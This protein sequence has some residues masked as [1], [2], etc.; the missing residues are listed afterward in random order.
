[1]FNGCTRLQGNT[2]Q[3][4]VIVIVIIGWTS[5]R[6]HCQTNTGVKHKT[7]K[8]GKK[9]FTDPDILKPIN[10]VSVTGR[11][12]SCPCCWV[13]PLHHQQLL[14]NSNHLQNSTNCN[15]QKPM[16]SQF[17]NELNDKHDL[18]ILIFSMNMTC[19]LPD[20]TEFFLKKSQK[21]TLHLNIGRKCY[22]G[23]LLNRQKYLYNYRV[24]FT[25]C[26]VFWDGKS[27]K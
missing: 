26:S 9:D 24:S 12:P 27:G 25:T 13:A 4:T 14:A 2:S 8:C 3:S 17:Q 10:S 21:I 19:F 23:G 11:T 18:N 15:F 1:M 22:T 7:V 5:N 6:H 16:K 20:K